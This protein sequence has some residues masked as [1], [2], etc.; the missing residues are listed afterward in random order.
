MTER[1]KKLRKQM[2]VQG[3]ICPERGYYMTESYRQTEGYPPILRRAMALKHILSNMS[4]NIL[5][6]ELI[7][8]QQTSKIRGGALLPEISAEWILE[9]MDFLADRQYDPYHPLSDKEK[10]LIKSYI[11]YWR[12]KSLF[13]Q[14][15]HL[16]PEK[17]KKYDHVAV[18]SMGF[19]EN[20][21]HFCHVAID[22][23]ELLALGLRGMAEKVHAEQEK[24]DYSKYEDMHK[25]HFLQSILICYDA[26]ELFAKRYADLAEKL[27]QTASSKERKQELIEIARICR[28]VPYEPAESFYEA[29]QSC[30]FVYIC[31][32]IEGWGAGMSLGRADQYLYPYY[33]KDLQQGIISP[34]KAKELLSLIF[35]KMNGVLN[36]QSEMVSK[37]MTGSPTMQGLTIGGITKAGKDAVNELSYLFLEAEEDVGLMNEDIVI[38]IN[39]KN[40]QAFILKACSVAKKLKGKLKFVSDKTTIAA[41]MSTGISEEDANGYIS[42][43]CHNPTIPAVT[44]DIGG[45]SMNYALILDLLLHRGISPVNGERLGIDLGDP[46]DLTSFEELTS[47]FEKEFEYVMN[48]LFYFKNADLSLYE[49]MP[50]PLLSSFYEGCIESGMDIN[51]NGVKLTTHTS[52]FVGAPNVGDSLAAIKKTVFDDKTLT[53]DRILKLLDNNLEGDDEALYFLKKA[54]KFGNNIPYV[55]DITRDVLAK[56]C[57]FLHRHRSYRGVKTTAGALAMTINIPFGHATGAQPD[58]RKR[59]MPLSEGGISPYQGRNTA[60]F[61]STLASVA[62][63]DQVRLSH[64]SILNVRISGKAVSTEDGLS[65]FADALITFCETGGNLVQFNFVDNEVLKDAQKRPELYQ[66]LLVRVAT[67]S[68]YFTELSKDLQDDIIRRYEFEEL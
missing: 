13:D 59:D 2:L 6:D 5:A 34:E 64:G 16:V 57:D 25:G 51:E 27:S 43:G 30:W 65:K 15:Q 53:M 40:P 68:A 58:G 3:S 14:L 37:M 41:L 45:S 7:V 1:V 18:S 28:K 35:I 17:L 63:L 39:S 8:G 52:A 12:G 67:Y 62:H 11:P 32:M 55:D 23:Q 36:P 9:E 20:G 19:S 50:C 44:H 47:A 10:E 66:D 33:K 38:R 54:P 24:L 4:I 42:T 31:L 49:Q 26:V 56:S 48:K 60:G 61:T 29:L 21:H 22:Y 46:R